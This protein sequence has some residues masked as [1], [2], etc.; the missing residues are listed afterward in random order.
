MTSQSQTAPVNRILDTLRQR[1]HEQYGTE[2]VSQLQHALQCATLAEQAGSNPSLVVA[3]LLHDLG[4]LLHDL[5]EDAAERGVDDRHEYRAMGLLQRLFGAAVAE[6]VRLHVSAK[7]YL[8]AVDKGYWQSLSPASKTSLELQGGIYSA[9]AAAEFIR[10][11]YAADAVELRR[12]D[13]LAKDPEAAT[14][15]LDHFLP[16]IR[17]CLI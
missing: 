12:W 13:D 6:P 8:C 9:A 10:Q 14:P 3:A 1:G 15:E 16:S 11:P 4:H 5:G 17:A 2:A 7:R